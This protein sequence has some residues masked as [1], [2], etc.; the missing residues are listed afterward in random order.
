M[1]GVSVVN[2]YSPLVGFLH[3]QLFG[4]EGPHCSQRRLVYLVTEQRAWP[5]LRP[6]PQRP[7][8]PPCPTRQRAVQVDDPS[9][10]VIIS[11]G[12]PILLRRPTY[13]IQRSKETPGLVLRQGTRTFDRQIDKRSTHATLEVDDAPQ[14]SAVCL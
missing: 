2:A 9:R 7:T 5:L 8:I 4:E 13:R 12:D 1:V 3:R 14:I 11:S 10:G 6:L